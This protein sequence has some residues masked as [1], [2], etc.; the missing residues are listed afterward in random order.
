MSV[1]QSDL[2]I[3]G[4]GP[5]G[6]A[7]AKE[8]NQ[9]GVQ[10]I[11]LDEQPTAGG[12]IY[13][14]V[15]GVSGR[16]AAI[17]GADFTEGRPLAEWLT[18]SD[19]DYRAG[20]TV[21]QVGTNGN[22]AYS[23]NGIA[24]QVQGKHILLATGAIERPVPLPGWTLPGVM[25]AGAAQI[26]MKTSGLIADGAVLVGS[27][28]LLYLVAAQML[29]AGSPPKAMVETQSFTD[30]RAALPHLAGAL[31]SWRQLTKGL[32][33]IATLRR[34]GVKRY[35]G[36]SDIKI[37][38][39]TAAEAVS[40]TSGG[41]SKRIETETVLLHLG[42]VPNTQ[43]SRALGLNHR[44]DAAQRC[45]HPVSDSYGQTSAPQI[46]IA[47][48]GAGI[49]GAKAATLS[50]R[51][52]TLNALSVMGKISTVERDA[53]CAPLLQSRTSENAIRPFLVRAY[54]PSGE[55]LRPAD[56]TIVCRC[57]EVTAGDIRQSVALGSKGPNQTKAFSRAGMGP[58]QG[59][60]CGLTVSEILAA[61]TGQTPDETGAY[62]I[63]SP[64]KPI[65]LGELSALHPIENEQ[66]TI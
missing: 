57:E 39:D 11:L 4:A 29:A 64:L 45:F 66:G 47:G 46:S 56:A 55:I 2:I 15:L 40:F 31:K 6:M 51:I 35:T 61:E 20:V 14:N 28:P 17:L 18:Q 36:A 62:R 8:A 38:G 41:H 63:R 60:F 23:K 25:T 43:I 16:Q 33:L 9:R 21:W 48:D 58:C 34:A 13:R 10:V 5:A 1:E 65:T 30:L 32:G 37:V 22:V 7:A 19:V 26:L 42:V 49:A 12:Q 59:R 53:A 44:Y 50:G 54:A 27:G 3:I 24:E 52:A